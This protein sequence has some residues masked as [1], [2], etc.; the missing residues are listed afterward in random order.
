M[1]KT[2]IFT[3]RPRVSLAR[4]SFCWWLH[5]R[6]LITS[7]WPH[8]YVMIT[9]SVISNSWDIDFIHGDIHGRSCKKIC[10]LM[11]TY[12]YIWHHEIKLDGCTM[13][14]L[15]GCKIHIQAPTI[16]PTLYS[17]HVNW[18]WSLSKKVKLNLLITV[19]G[20]RNSGSCEKAPLL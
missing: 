15:T 6:L 19:Y 5:S 14:H 11:L 16:L 12:L 13:T 4:F 1:I 2:T 7:Q 18:I 3:H 17:T 8:N 10:L 9:W 20:Y